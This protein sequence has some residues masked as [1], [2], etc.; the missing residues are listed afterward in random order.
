[1]AWFAH[2]VESRRRNLFNFLLFLRITPFLP[3]FFINLASP[4]LGVPL[5]Y[6]VLA[7]FFGISELSDQL[8]S[9]H[10]FA[11]SFVVPATF[12]H[13]SAGREL[14]QMT[15]LGGAF[16]F[17]RFLWLSLLGVVV[18]LPTWGPVQRLLDK[19]LNR[20]SAIDAGLLDIKKK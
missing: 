19:L 3:N 16:D 13:V 18:L 12:M 10:S 20:E 17:W 6:F 2:Q 4:L 15:E 7:T 1:M 5:H 8:V 14:Q 11:N 9:V